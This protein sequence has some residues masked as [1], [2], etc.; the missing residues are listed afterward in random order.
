VAEAFTG[1]PPSGID[2]LAGLAADNTKAYF[3]GNRGTYANDVAAPL[4]ALVIAVGQRLRDGAGQHVCF[5]PAV[6]K[7]LFRINR[8]TRFSADKTPYHPWVDAIWW[9]GLP[10]ARRAPAFIFRLSA[11]GLVAGAGILGLRDTQLDRYRTAVAD[12]SSGRA[13]HDLL[14]RLAATLP[15][16]EITQPARKRV[17]APYPQDHPRRDLLRCDSLHASVQRAHPPTLASPEFADTLAGLLTPFAQ[18]HH[19]LVDHVTT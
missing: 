4:R 15:D 2:F 19:W 11:D 10:D 12:D 17:P 7:S 5:E 13:L 18:L 3:D 9:G 16:V 1:F 8:D 6:G 14:T